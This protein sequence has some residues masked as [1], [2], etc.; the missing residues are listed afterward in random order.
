MI[1]NIARIQNVRYALILFYVDIKH[2]CE[3]M[4]LDMPKLYQ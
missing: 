1:F 4:A 3:Y 2:T